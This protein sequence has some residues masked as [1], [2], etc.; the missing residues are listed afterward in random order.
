MII[1]GQCD[2]KCIQRDKETQRVIYVYEARYY[3]YN[4]QHIPRFNNL[5]WLSGTHA[6]LRIHHHRR[7]HHVTD[8][9]PCPTSINKPRGRR[10]PKVIFYTNRQTY[11]SIRVMHGVFLMCFKGNCLMSQI[12]LLQLNFCFEKQ[13]IIHNNVILYYNTRTSKFLLII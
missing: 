9:Y 1:D 12:F 5:R 10:P 6:R 3:R 7:Q 8:V 11:E 2:S 13:T 4:H